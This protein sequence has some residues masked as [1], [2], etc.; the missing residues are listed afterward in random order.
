MT[1]RVE[2]RTQAMQLLEQEQRHLEREVGY[3]VPTVT[4]VTHRG[5]REW[6]IF[7]RLLKDRIVFIGA[8]IDDFLANLVIAQFLFLESEDPDKEIQ[9]YV[10]SPG[11]VVTSGLAMYDTMQYVRCPVS[12]MCLGQAASMA[13]V[14]LAAGH[15]GRRFALPHSRMMIHQPLGGARG[16]ATDIEIQAREI[17]K[18]KET[19]IDILVDATNKGRDDLA[20]DIERDFYLSAG[21][22]KEY[23]LIDDV[24]PARKK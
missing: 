6:N 8:E 3:I 15:R 20:R 1:R 17:K 18:I 5:E 4:E 13:A 7:S 10:N 22:A 12:T 24:L 11:G 14:L 23:G 9:V 16:Q 2:N 19:L 21:Q